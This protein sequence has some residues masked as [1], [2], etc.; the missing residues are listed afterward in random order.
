[1]AATKT[2]ILDQAMGRF[3]AMIRGTKTHVID[4]TFGHSLAV[5]TDIFDEMFE[6]SPTV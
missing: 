1:M 6:K 4:E 2:H 3:Q 5:K